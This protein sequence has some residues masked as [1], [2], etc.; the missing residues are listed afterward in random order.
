MA[1]LFTGFRF[2][3]GGGN[4]IG[5]LGGFYYPIASPSNIT[6]FGESGFEVETSGQYGLVFNSP[7]TASFIMWG[8]GGTKGNDVNANA[9]AGG[10]VEGI[11]SVT[12]GTTYIFV[13]GGIAPNPGDPRLASPF[14]GGGNGGGPVAAGG[15]GGGYSGLF[16]TSISQANAR[17]ISGGGGGSNGTDAGSN[18]TAIGGGGGGT[19]GTSG[20]SPGGA[21]GGGTQST[22]GG[23]GTGPGQN[24]TAGTALQGG[25]GGTRTVNQGSGGG[26]GG[27]YFGGGGGAA[28][29][30]GTGGQSGAPGGGGSGYLHPSVTAGTLYTASPNSTA[31]NSSSPFR[32]T[33]GNSGVSGKFV[34]RP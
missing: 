11:L 19:N 13:V 22:G 26:G 16:V 30:F 34:I 3:F 8:A 23:G 7:E 21:G 33:A 32:G 4:Q 2:G 29:G 12:S 14:G 27:G 15:A 20:V 17:L 1:P 5:L 18:P 24:G 25:T 28:G 9:G 10:C 6:S 31:G